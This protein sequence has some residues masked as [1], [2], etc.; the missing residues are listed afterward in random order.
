MFR[1]AIVVLVAS[2]LMA[3]AQEKPDPKAVAAQLE[4]LAG[5]WKVETEV[6][7]GKERK[8]R[9]PSPHLRRRQGHA[10]ERQ[11]GE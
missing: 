9:G 1:N 6:N 4:K 7:E 2:G 10:A 3:A 8:P 11:D 5:T